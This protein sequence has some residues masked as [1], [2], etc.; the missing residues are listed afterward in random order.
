MVV[1]TLLMNNFNVH[2]LFDSGVT[3]SFITRRIITKIGK[4]VKVIEK[5]G[6][7][8]ELQWETR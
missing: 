7:E 3:Y 2:V 6:L 5:K 4:R 8:L 1:G